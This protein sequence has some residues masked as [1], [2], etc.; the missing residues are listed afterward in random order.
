MHV[1]VLPGDGIGPE[2]TTATSQVL[3]AAS[4]Q[5]QLGLVLDEHAVGHASLARFGTT[6][7]PDLLGLVKAADGLILGPTATF[8]FKDEAR[9]EINPSRHFRKSLDLFANIRPARTYPGRTNRVGDFDLVV[10]RENT[11]GFYADRNMEEGNAELRVTPDVVISMRRIT[12]PCCERIAEVACQL[13]MKRRKHLTIVHKANVL[14]MGDGMFLDI[15]KATASRYP[16]LAVD[17]VL[18]DAAMAHVVREPGRFDVLVTTNM[19]GDILSDLTAELSGSLGLGGALNMGAD[20]AMA[21]AAH[22]SAPDI[23]GRGIA[24]P[25][26][27]ILSAALLLDWHG[28]RTRQPRFVSAAAAIEAAV[29]DAIGQGQSTQD[30]GGSLGTAEAAAAITARLQA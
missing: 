12:R 10:V 18:V 17:E 5:F 13:A 28:T 8:D 24:N 15:C 7:R 23:A 19:F 21:Q 16:E 11:E 6:V 20:H 2:I 4:E 3:R 26:S 27:L 9:G 29:A 1:V 22:G 14:R 30:I 25:V